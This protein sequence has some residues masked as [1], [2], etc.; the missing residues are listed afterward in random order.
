MQS[1]TI[2][3]LFVLN[4][5]IKN[6][7]TAKSNE[8]LSCFLRLYACFNAVLITIIDRHLLQMRCKITSSEAILP[9]LKKIAFN[10]PK[11][12]RFACSSKALTALSITHTSLKQ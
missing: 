11:L 2:A 8:L 10:L 6:S 3:I 12:L 4:S 1:R 5:F 9:T 7:L